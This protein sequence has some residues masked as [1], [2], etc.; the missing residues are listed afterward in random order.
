[1]KRVLVLGVNGLIGHTMY[2]KLKQEG[3][4]VF[5]TMRR[6][7]IEFMQYDFLQADTIIDGL[8][9]QEIS[10]VSEVIL[11]I[12][13]SVVVNCIGIT[14]R[15]DEI[16]NSIQAIKINALLP[17]QIAKICQDMS[18]RMIHLSTDCV[19][20]GDSGLYTEDSIPDASD[21]YGRT[22]AMGEVLDNPNCLTLRSSFLGTEISDRTELLEWLLSQKG[23]TIKG[24]TKAIYSGVSTVYLSSV[25]TE[26]LRH[27]PQLSGL[28]QIAPDTPISKY[29]LLC[30]AKNAFNIDVEIVGNDS[31]VSDKSLSGARLKKVMNYRVPSWHDML[32]E[33]AEWDLDKRN[34]RGK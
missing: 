22:K 3:F 28:Y 15:K 16:S 24:Y 26:I 31:F 32:Q 27:Y 4:E 8:D 21:M 20:S 19:F 12:Q 10:N 14:R 13:P 7:K 9:V 5:G 30:I 1:M 29:D 17:H 11:Q 33:L 2:R 25:I 6:A 18:I 23:R 34:M